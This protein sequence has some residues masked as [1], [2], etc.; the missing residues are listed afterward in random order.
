MRPGLFH[1]L[2]A[3]VY[4]TPKYPR[5]NFTQKNQKKS[6]HS[7]LIAGGGGAGNGDLAEFE[8][9]ICSGVDKVKTELN[10]SN[11]TALH[12]AVSQGHSMVIKTL[13]A[14][15]VRVDAVAVHE[16]HLTEGHGHMEAVQILLTSEA[17][18][19]A[20]TEFRATPLSIAAQNG[21]TVP[22]GTVGGRS[23]QQGEKH[24]RSD[25]TLRRRARQTYRECKG[26][27][28]AESRA[29]PLH[30]AAQE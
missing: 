7:S 14:N 10:D 12:K 18:I 16:L 24:T 25:T 29:T 13:V 22:A 6:D 4:C 28:T 11:N 2:I 17:Q 21:Y 27:D 3:R 15:K 1:I 9:L 19:E 30:L 5:Y 20:E 26:T 23:P 8:F